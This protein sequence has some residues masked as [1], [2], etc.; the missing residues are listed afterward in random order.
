M[1]ADA[2]IAFSRA[3]EAAWDTVRKS[4]YAEALGAT[5]HQAPDVDTLEARLTE[6]REHRVPDRVWQLDSAD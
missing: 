1:D 3:A 2:R 5:Q 6:M 4:P